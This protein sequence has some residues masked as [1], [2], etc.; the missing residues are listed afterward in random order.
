MVEN[1]GVALRAIQW[2]AILPW[3][4]IVKSFRLAVTLRLMTF[5]AVAVLL[6]L[7]GWW[8][9]A[10]IFSHGGDLNSSW[11]SAFGNQSAW[12]VI[13]R[14]VP[15][16]P[17]ARDI[18]PY[19]S[20]LD[21]HDWGPIRTWAVLSQPVWL[22]LSIQP[23]TAGESLTFRDFLSLLL[24]SVW[25]LAVWAY[26]GAAISRVAAVQLATGE[27]VGWTASL[28]WAGAKW[29]AYFSAP[30]LPMLGVALVVL[31]ILV[32]GLLMKISFVAI[33]AA[34]IWPLVLVAGFVMTIL[35]AGVLLGWPLMWATI[36]VEGTDSFDALNRTYAYVFQRPIRYFFYVIVAALIGWLGWFVVENFAAS[37][38][39]LA[40]WAAG[41]GLGQS[42]LAPAA[43]SLIAFWGGWVKLLAIGY[44]F[45]YF[46]VASTAIY[47]LLRRDVD[48][49]ETDEVFLD[50]DTSEEK[51]GLP[52]LQRDA[53]GAP[54]I[55]ENAA[56]DVGS[57][58][59]K[60]KDAP[61]A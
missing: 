13:D 28:R 23:A 46:G 34:L 52:K 2:S 9:L 3:L 19:A 27:Q 29:L 56:A 47:F 12:Q 10:E 20:G 45:S 55:V 33:L 17:F 51:F 58:D 21:I 8:T 60:V 44:S 48:A 36:S 1:E 59:G 7:L 40:S 26:F 18:L 53:A 11:S 16:R 42:S 25:S 6:T 38:I 30:L 61:N 50:A 4:S 37:V 32:L 57:S 43:T 22:L 54:E 14:T 5:G 39:W 35:L 15:S 31:P 41:W 24:S 49:R